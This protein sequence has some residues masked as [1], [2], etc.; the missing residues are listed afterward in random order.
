MYQAI[1]ALHHNRKSSL[2][3]HRFVTQLF[4]ARLEQPSHLTIHSELMKDVRMDCSVTGNIGQNVLTE[5]V[6]E[7]WDVSIHDQPYFERLPPGSNKH[8]ILPNNS[9]IIYK[10]TRLDNKVFRCNVTIYET[11][12]I[13]SR[14]FQ[15]KVELK[16]NKTDSKYLKSSLDLD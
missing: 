8:D 15:T 2:S 11:L 12:D 5:Y 6:W 3:Y 13:V 7:S 1:M 9:L 16:V 14:A 4:L 10:V